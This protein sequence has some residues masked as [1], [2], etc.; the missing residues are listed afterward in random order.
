MKPQLLDLLWCPV[1]RGELRD[2]GDNVVCGTCEASY[3]VVDGVVRMLRPEELTEVDL[4]ELGSRDEETAWYDT[5]F[6]DYTNAV[7]VPTTVRRIGQPTGPVLDLAAGSGRIT[8]ALRHLGQPVVALD[9][10]FEMLR[11]LVKRCDDDNVLAVQADGRSLP[12]RDGVIHATTSGEVY[13]DFRG[14][15][16]GRVV[17]ELARVMR[18]RAP[19]SLS[20]LNYNLMYKIWKLIGNEGA[21]EGEHLLGGDFYYLRMTRSELRREIGAEFDIEEITGIRN[22]PARSI[23]QG[24]R[25]A[26]LPRLGD[27]FL[28]WMTEKGHRIDWA[29]EKTPLSYLTGF[30]WIVK[31]TR[32][33][34]PGEPELAR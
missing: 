23:A 17:R 32:R 4:R 31:A 8:D 13:G 14:E 5:I 25:K 24:I 15:D 12:I 20:T 33:P 18:P 1:D 29:I 2:E 27:R 19:L 28:D 11:L 3:P 21:R 30:F 7:E 9:Y 26:R 16:R 6:G 10:S 22:I 34:R